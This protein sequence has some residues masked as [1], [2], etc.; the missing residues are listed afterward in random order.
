MAQIAIGIS[1][2]AHRKFVILA[3]RTVLL[4]FKKSAIV[5]VVK[6][7]KAEDVDDIDADKTATEINPSSPGM[8]C[9]FM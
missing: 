7:F 1:N 4:L 8:F 3:I 5:T 9:W 6:L 2:T